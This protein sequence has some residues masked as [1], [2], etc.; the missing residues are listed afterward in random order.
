MGGQFQSDHVGQGLTLQ[1]A[2]SSGTGHVLALLVSGQTHRGY[3][4][5]LRLNNLCLR[6]TEPYLNEGVV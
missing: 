4:L 2:E 5:G 6:F 1:V 3:L